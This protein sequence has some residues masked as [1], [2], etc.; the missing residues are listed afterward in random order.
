MCLNILA[1]YIWTEIYKIKLNIE[2]YQ[3][4]ELKVKALTLF[5]QGM[6]KKQK[7]WARNR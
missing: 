6:N 1:Y 4:K 5:I 3:N 2:N 7:S